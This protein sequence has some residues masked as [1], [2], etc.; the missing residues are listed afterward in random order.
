MML[1][2]KPGS[3]LFPCTTL[4]RS[5]DD[6]WIF[7][8]YGTVDLQTGTLHFDD[9]LSKHAWAPITSGTRMESAAGRSASGTL[10]NQDGG[11]MVWSGSAYNLNSG[12]LLNGQVN[13]TN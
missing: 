2:H 1:L 8:N 12:V 9:L 13:Y 11:V 3:L 5:F 6:P 4:F 7:N 10:D